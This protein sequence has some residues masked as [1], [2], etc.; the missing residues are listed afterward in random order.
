MGG[1][2]PPR[3]QILGQP[4]DAV[5]KEQ[6]TRML[7]ERAGRDEPGAYVCLTNVHTT[8][9]SQR[10]PSLRAAAGNAFLSVP[11]G[12]PLVWI[13]RRRGHPHVEKVTG[14][15]FVPMVAEAGLK[16]GLR[17]FFFGGGNGVAEA[18]AAGLKRMVPGTEV[19][20]TMTP[21][22]SPGADWSIDRLKAEVERT[23]AQIVWVGL[24]APR[25]EIWMSRV[26]KEVGAPLMAGVGAAFDFLAET[27]KPAPAALR[28]IG[29]E[30]AFRLIS[31]PRRL[32]RR[33]LLGNGT[34]VYL[35]LRS[36]LRKGAAGR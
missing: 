22:F 24:G 19:V 10:S 16:V 29:L 11:D 26:A 18:A 9:E 35:L 30:W 2:T 6:A 7:V 36:A 21:P 5:D 12:M 17:H 32:W 27:K 3:L 13:L 23:Q 4:V 14:I 20:G 31:E 33:Y 8:V 15:E 34:F 28:H 25:Q 1:G